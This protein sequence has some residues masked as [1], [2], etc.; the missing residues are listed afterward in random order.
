MILL[1]THVLLWLDQGN[2]RLGK[3]AL[4]LIESAM[5]DGG[6]AVSAISFW[7]IAMLVEKRRIVTSLDLHAWRDD[8]LRSGL[9]EFAIDGECGIQTALL[10]DLPSDPAD[11]MIVA[12]ALRQSAALVT[13]DERL[14]QWSGSVQRV[15]ARI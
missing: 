6:V 7:E 14:L 2:S 4:Q 15:D 8:L 3:V 11:R 5:A 10:H 1:D 13:A 12:T 9:I